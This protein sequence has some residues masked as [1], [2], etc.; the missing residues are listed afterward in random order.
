MSQTTA[1]KKTT[2]KATAPRA[3][4]AGAKVPQDHKVAADAPEQA[5][6]EVELNGHTWKVPKDAMDDF[7]LLDDL[8]ALDQQEDP[9]RLP[10]VLRR[11]LGDQWKEAM[12]T[13]RD[14][15]TGRVTVEAGTVF[16]Y[17]LM[18]ALNP[19]SSRS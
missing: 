16:F 10:A 8:N 1:R 18:K 4:P 11:F 3:V 17:D 15:D 14:K 19:N 6:L 2:K 5:F 7:E 12:D 9:T 13:L